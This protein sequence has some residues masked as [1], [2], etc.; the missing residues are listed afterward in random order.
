MIELLV[1]MVIVA[2]LA[3]VAIPNYTEYVQRGRRQEAKATLLQIAQWQERVRTQTNSYATSTNDLPT[4]LRTVT[5]NN[6]SAYNITIDAG[7]TA[8][9]Y[10]LTAT[11]TGVMANDPCGDFTLSSL[12]VR[13]LANNTRT[14]DQCW[15]R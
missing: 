7:A 3:A 1:I 9:A 6:A 5:I 8:T 15:G 2:I 12:N 10:G 14:M 13:G 4:N 11:R